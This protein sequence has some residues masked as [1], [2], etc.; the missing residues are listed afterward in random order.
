MILVVGNTFF[1]PFR[2]RQMQGQSQAETGGVYADIRRGF[3]QGDNEADDV[4]WKAA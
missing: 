2:V 1:R 4:L 3:P